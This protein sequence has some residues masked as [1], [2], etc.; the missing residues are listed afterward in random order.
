MQ[1]ITVEELKSRMDAGEKLNVIDV[2]EP[3]EHAQFNIGGKLLPL[4]QIM[5][6][7]VDG[8]NGLEDQELIVYCRSGNR[9]A[10]ACLFLETM[11]FKHC[12][13]LMGGMNAWED[14][15]GHKNA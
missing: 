4:G 14:Q 9:S 12:I 5:S 3:D 8:L 6:M 15:F 1:T 7:Q 11:G 13:N 10:Q 2:R